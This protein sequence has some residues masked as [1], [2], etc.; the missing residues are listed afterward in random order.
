MKKRIVSL[1]LLIV[2]VVQLLPITALAAESDKQPDSGVFSSGVQMNPL[3][4]HDNTGISVSS[5]Y[6]S[7][8]SIPN[9]AYYLTTLAD[10]AAYLRSAMEKRQNTVTF[11]YYTTQEPS[12]DI[13]YDIWDLSLEETGVPTQGDYLR[14]VWEYYYFQFYYDYVDGGYELSVTFDIYYYTDAY[15]EAALT[16]EIYYLLDYLNFTE[17]ATDY[18]KI[19]TV[20]TFLCTYVTYDYDT[21]YDDSYMLKYTAYA[22]LMHGTAVCQGYAVLFYRLMRELDIPVRVITG[23]S[24]GVNHAWNIVAINGKYYNMDSTWDSNYG[25]N[26]DYYQYFMRSPNNFPDHNRFSDYTSGSF[27]AAYPMSS[28]DF[29]LPI[30]WY[31][32]DENWYYLTEYDFL[33]GWQE[34]DGYTYYFS[35]GGRMQTGWV[36]DGGNW[37][38]LWSDG[39]MVT[40]TVEIDGVTYTFDDNGVMIS[41]G[42]EVPDEP[43]SEQL[44]WVYEDGKWYYFD[45]DG[46]MV[47]DA[48][49]K[50]SLG[51]CYLGSDG[52]MVTNCWLEDSK[53]WCYIGANGYCETNCW[54]QDSHGWL[55]LDSEGSMTKNQWVMTDGYW[56]YLD[57]EGYMATN[58]W[59]KDSYG[60]CYLG[61]NG[62][63]LT[64]CWAI[65]SKGW[66]YIGANGYCETECWKQDS[67][68]WLY[69]DSEGS[70]TKEAWVCTDGCWYY[71]DDE[72][73]MVTGS[74]DIDGT[75]YY[76]DENGIWVA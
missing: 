19:A 72:G 75:S 63:M 65:D 60:W 10:A 56:Y 5:K 62:A 58:C 31:Q 76:F 17:D 74:Y 6:D 44:G 64:N 41:E 7:K 12:T 3:Y 2:M 4:N 53:G 47:T 9:N 24:G 37:Y 57:A 52:A 26:F 35:D 32:E 15:Q 61:S 66:C 45:E 33:T 36:Y 50:D 13:F 20:Y 40:G 51:W 11:Y 48:W 16:E 34:I 46:N 23:Q 29:S 70:M 68:G 27:H 54:K 73:Y 28:S 39:C 42:E 71:L 18:E 59:R 49:R 21:L 69:L 55:Y 43:E 8:Y 38:Y 67:Y 14:W 1:I 25:S 22:A 30:G